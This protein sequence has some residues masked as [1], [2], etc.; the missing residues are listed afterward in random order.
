MNLGQFVYP[1]RGGY[2]RLSQKQGPYS[3]ISQKQPYKMNIC[4][5][6]YMYNVPNVF[7][8]NL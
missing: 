1:N 2:A 6:H 8:S 7:I 5:V 4:D 3:R